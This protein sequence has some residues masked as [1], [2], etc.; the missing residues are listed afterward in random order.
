[1]S[2]SSS[3][4]RSSVVVAAGKKL[5]AD[6]G[7][8][9]KRCGGRGA[10]RHCLHRA[11]KHFVFHSFDGA[12]CHLL[13]ALLLE[14]RQPPEFRLCQVEAVD[15]LGEAEIGVDTRDD[16]ARIDRDQLD[17]DHRDAH[18]GIDHEPL[19]ENQ[20]DDVR[21]PARA[22][23]PLQVVAGGSL[24]ADCHGFGRFPSSGFLEPVYDDDAPAVSRR[25]WR[26]RSRSSRPESRSPESRSSSDCDSSDSSFDASRYWI[27]FA[28]SISTKALN[29]ARSA[30]TARFTKRRPDAIFSIIPLGSNS[31]STITRVRLSSSLWKLTTPLCDIPDVVFQAMRSFLRRSV[32]LPSHCRLLNQIFSCHLSLSLPSSRTSTTRCMNF[33]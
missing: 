5:L 3:P 11:G 16:D 10:L 24:C 28:S 31:M 22:R 9:G 32:T 18:I 1:M 15:G 4:V 17:P 14:L 13:G 25:S 33:G 23:R 8:G 21:K 26:A 30:C 6:S 20:V 12:F 7:S 19:V 27:P 2:M 29:R